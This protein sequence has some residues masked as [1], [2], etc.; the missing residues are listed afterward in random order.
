MEHEVPQ[1]L[2]LKLLFTLRM[3]M[4]G[5]A[6]ARGFVHA[7]LAPFRAIFQEVALTHSPSGKSKLVLCRK[8]KAQH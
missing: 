1:R 6:D 4:M 7:G 2:A 8:Q 3:L 5:S